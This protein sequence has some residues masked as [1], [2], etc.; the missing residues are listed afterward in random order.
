MELVEG[1]PLFEHAGIVVDAVSCQRED[2]PPVEPGEPEIALEDELD[3]EDSGV[4]VCRWPN[5]D[6]SIVMAGSK[7]EAIIALDEWDAADPS[8]L[9]PMDEYLVDFRLNS[10]GE[11]RRRA[12]ST[13]ATRWTSSA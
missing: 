1:N 3:E 13:F 4:Y 6:A 12:P 10:R 2:A 9:T 8:W 7:R 5:G 11:I